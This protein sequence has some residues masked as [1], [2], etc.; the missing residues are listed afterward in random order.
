MKR[1]R[2]WLYFALF[3]LVFGILS[4]ARTLSGYYGY[5]S[6]ALIVIFSLIVVWRWWKDPHDPRD[7]GFGMSRL[8][9]PRSWK[10][11]LYD[12]HDDPL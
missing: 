1:L 3:L 2:P 7:A 9:L 10:R 5:F 12:E 4:T 6:L 11:W 8:P